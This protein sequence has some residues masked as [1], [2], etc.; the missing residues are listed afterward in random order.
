MSGWNFHPG[1]DMMERN[2][3]HCLFDRCNS[4]KAVDTAEVV[5]IDVAV[6]TSEV[7]ESCFHINLLLNCFHLKSG[8]GLDLI[9]LRECIF[10]TIP[11]VIG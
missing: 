10:S 5:G 3:T 6:G 4:G 7:A 1:S 11:F 2:E 9:H 8:Y